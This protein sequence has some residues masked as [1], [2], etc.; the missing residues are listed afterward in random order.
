MNNKNTKGCT[1][2][3]Y[4]LRYEYCDVGEVLL[5]AGADPN[6]LDIP[7][8]IWDSSHEEIHLLVRYGLLILKP[9]IRYPVI[10]H[11]ST[12]LKAFLIPKMARR[13]WVLLKC[14]SRFLSLQQRAVITANCP[15][16]KRARGEFEVSE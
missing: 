2:L 15:E 4:A 9:G 5:Q 11:G 3:Y 8:I 1:P 16:R 10:L 6:V 7:G 12:E 14:V 13:R